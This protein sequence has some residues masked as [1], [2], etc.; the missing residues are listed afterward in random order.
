MRLIIFLVA[1]CLFFFSCTPSKPN[2]FSDSV[3]V[4]IA[5]LQDRRATDSLLKFLHSEN[6][7]YRK[8]AALAF[9]SVQDSLAALALGT[10]LLEDKDAEVRRAA[11]FALGQTGTFAAVNSLIPSLEDSNHLVVRESLEALGKAI[12]KNDISVLLNY[13]TTDSLTS[14]GLAWAFYQ[15]GL[16]NL[17]DSLIENKEKQFLDSIYK[18]KTRLGAAHFFSRSRLTGHGFEE[19]IIHSAQKDKSAEVRMAAASALK[20][21]SKEKALPVL[22]QI[23]KD[24][25]DYRVRISAVRS[26]A[27]F[28]V[29]ETI[30]LLLKSL[31]DKSNNVA[32]A[33]S[34]I[35]KNNI[36]VEQKADVYKS[37]AAANWRVQSNLYEAILSVDPSENAVRDIKTLYNSSPN[38]YQKAALLLALSK[39]PMADSFIADELFKSKVPVI[40]SSAA[41]ALT[42]INRA[43]NFNSKSKPAFA[44]WY[45]K[46]L[47]DGD[48]AVIGTIA[49]ALADS[50]LD[51][52]NGIKDFSFLLV[53]KAKLSLPKDYETWQPL[54]E[55]I[56]YFEGRQKPSPPK[57]GFNH[58]VN[59]ELVKTIN[60]DQRIAVKTTK[61]KI[62]LKLFVEQAPGSVAN[63]VELVNRK[64]FDGKNVHRVVPNF[65][66]QTGCYRGDGYGSENYSIRSE[67][68]MNKY[69]TGS[70]GMASAG[71]DTEGTQW[72]I[73]HSPTP[74]LDGRYTLFAEVISGM[75]VVDET[76]VGDQII[77]IR[78]ID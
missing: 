6:A 42:T 4:R 63:F 45:K 15:I 8:E 58:P 44:E 33:G 24:E 22:D 49:G 35:I 68:Y 9:A 36:T 19:S 48:A 14:E 46:A 13:R 66:I 59:W 2:K 76:E 56:A 65:V 34:E 21:I 72:F 20:K 57:N 51:Y 74:H 32:I 73:T 12:S 5:D 25:F 43:K 67:F 11:A 18:E 23:L 70:V 39:A 55:A 28:P 47:L 29:K 62:I 26:L 27:A 10:L 50:T 71:K 64:Y 77:S 41:L 37:I 17:S 75:P 7:L 60:K 30:S 16:R 31:T 1:A 3:L 69:K 53:A 54:E 78:L 40:K 38:N 61:G 52:K